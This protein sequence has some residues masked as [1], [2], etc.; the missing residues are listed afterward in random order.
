MERNSKC[1]SV[2]GRFASV[3]LG[4]FSEIP[5]VHDLLI[6]AEVAN[7]VQSLIFYVCSLAVR[8]SCLFCC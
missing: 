4:Q 7:G 3:G 5:H 1:H 8:L 2:V 6:L